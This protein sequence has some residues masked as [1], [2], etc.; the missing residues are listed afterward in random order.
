MIQFRSVK[1]YKVVHCDKCP[2][3]LH[4][5]AAMVVALCLGCSS[6]SESVQA[7]VPLDAGAV[8]DAQDAGSHPAGDQAT[9]CLLTDHRGAIDDG[10][11]VANAVRGAQTAAKALSWKVV[12][13]DPAEPDTAGQLEALNAMMSTGCALVVTVGFLVNEATQQAAAAKPQQKFAFLDVA[14]DPP[15]NNVWSQVYV[16]NEAAFLAGYLAAGTSKTGKIAIIGAMQI[17]QVTDFMD[18]FA[19]GAAY[20]NT[21]NNT[22]VEIQGW[23]PVGQVGV[24]IG[25]FIDATK[26]QELASGFLDKGA[27]I[28]LSA[29]GGVQVS[30]VAQAVSVK[31]NAYFVGPDLDWGAQDAYKGIVLTSILKKLDIS[32]PRVAKAVAD[33]VFKSG[34]QT[35]SLATGEVDIA[36]FHDAEAIVPGEVKSDLADIR[37]QIL[38]GKI[39][40]KP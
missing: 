4:R 12:V 35:G 9:L 5:A 17:P 1:S 16:M 25:D 30:G 18:G 10:S 19:V 29:T 14:L 8:P 33:G 34:T 26:A 21:R 31:G 3:L 2:K 37:S 39:K 6:E 27:D 32:V 23:D 20:Y 38:A 13:G 11:F 36:P 15:M 28:I 22:S 40:T 24:F 7:M